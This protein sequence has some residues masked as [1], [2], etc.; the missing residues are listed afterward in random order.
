VKKKVTL[1]DTG[2]G[3]LH[4]VERA[5]RKAGAEVVVAAEVADCDAIVVPG[6][7]AFRDCTSALAGTLGEAITEHVRA[8]K[9]YLGICLGL[10]ALFES[11][12]EAPGCKGLG[13]FAGHVRKLAP[14]SPADK[15][16]HTGWNVVEGTHPI[17][18]KSAYFYFVHSYVAEP[19]DRSI[20]C[21]TTTHGSDRFVSA[22]AKDNVLAVQFH[23]EKSQREGLLLLER[24]LKV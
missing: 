18:P 13:I 23:P 16:P 5:L 19:N 9:P 2:L 21:G 7:G 14:K 3:N 24:W 20:I 12:D 15:V 6:Q 4:S 1:V 10:Q 17:L 22:V 11:S 8:G